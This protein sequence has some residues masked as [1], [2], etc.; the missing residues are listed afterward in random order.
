M[1]DLSD[2]RDYHQVVMK[3]PSGIKTPQDYL[4]QLS[5]DVAMALVRRAAKLARKPGGIV[6]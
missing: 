6:R 5:D 3:A 4:Q 1:L 2:G